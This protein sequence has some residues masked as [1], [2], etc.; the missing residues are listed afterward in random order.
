M[1]SFAKCSDFSKEARKLDFYGNA[2]QFS[3]ISKQRRGEGLAQL[4]VN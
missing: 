1:P 4:G 2:S 3:S